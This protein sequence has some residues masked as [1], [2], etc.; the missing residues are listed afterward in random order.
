MFQR[1]NPSGVVRMRSILPGAAHGPRKSLERLI[2]RRVPVA[3]PDRVQ[4]SEAVSFQLGIPIESC[5][6]GREQRLIA[7]RTCAD[8]LPH[9]ELGDV[10]PQNHV[11][12][13]MSERKR[14]LIVRG[15]E[16]RQRISETNGA[17][18]ERKCLSLVTFNHQKA[19]SMIRSPAASGDLVPDPVDA[20]REISVTTQG[21]G[22]QKRLERFVTPR[23]L[24]HG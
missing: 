10:V 4:S 1:C 22:F 7:R 12:Q 23:D 2:G 16:S 8:R 9:P 19:V 11:R 20:E 24:L 6:H 15:V 21:S 5:L 17:T 18:G 14:Q 3:G 13:L